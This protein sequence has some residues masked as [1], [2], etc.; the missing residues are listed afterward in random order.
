MSQKP[1]DFEALA[2]NPFYVLG[3]RPDCSRID[4]EREGQ[5]LLGMLGLKLK[6]AATY[7]SPLG[8]R[9]RT[10]DKVRAAMAALRDHEK[11]LA[12]EFWASL[13]PPA[14]PPKPPPIPETKGPG[15]APFAGAF[16]ALGWRRS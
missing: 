11:R 10:E 7:M 12:H 1:D 16:A 9:P 3:L 14:A 6:S 2:D 13:P 15:P 4:I 5:K 8:P